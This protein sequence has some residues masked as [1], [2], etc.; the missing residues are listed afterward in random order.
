LIHPYFFELVVNRGAVKPV[1]YFFAPDNHPIVFDK[2]HLP[3][4]GFYRSPN[5][6]TRQA[7]E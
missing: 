5:I 6:V 7:A 3:V 1:Y 2:N 4:V